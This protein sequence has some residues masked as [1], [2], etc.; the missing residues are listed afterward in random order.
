MIDIFLLLVACA[1]L[2]LV[3][4]LASFLPELAYHLREIQSEL[5]R[6]RAENQ[7]DSRHEG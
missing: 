5:T 1:I 6:I 7:G 3:W 2:A 4:K